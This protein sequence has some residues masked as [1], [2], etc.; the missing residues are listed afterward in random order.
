MTGPTDP[1]GPELAAAMARHPAGRG[2]T[3]GFHVIEL[4]PAETK[5]SLNPTT[6]QWEDIITRPPVRVLE[7]HG[8][9]VLFRIGSEH[10]LAHHEHHRHLSP[11][12]RARLWALRLLARTLH[13]LPPV[14][15]TGAPTPPTTTPTAPVPL[16]AVRRT[17]DAEH[18]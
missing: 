3:I 8:C 12:R 14:R 5:P 13:R 4:A 11:P 16:K 17:P 15:P 2:R 6:L 18:G 9:G 7:C 1:D 10:L